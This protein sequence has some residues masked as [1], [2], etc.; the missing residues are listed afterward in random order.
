M[1]ECI[2]LVHPLVGVAV[3][4]KLVYEYALT[5][6]LLILLCHPFLHSSSPLCVSRLKV[7]I[8]TGRTARPD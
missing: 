1:L 4:T 8:M 3:H 5:L 2:L 6:S 7:K